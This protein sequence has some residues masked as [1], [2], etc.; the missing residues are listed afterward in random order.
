MEEVN[1]SHGKSREAQVLVS[2]SFSIS[3][4]AG[5]GCVVG[6]YSVEAT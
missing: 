2:K 3:V 1:E 5:C 6:I 4:S